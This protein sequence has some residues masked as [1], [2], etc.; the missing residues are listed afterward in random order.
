M[1]TNLL[2]SIVA[3]TGVM[4]GVAGLSRKLFAERKPDSA[5]GAATGAVS[6]ERGRH[7]IR[8]AGCNDC[9]TPGFMQEGENVPEGLWLTGVP[10]GW[11]GPWGTTYASNLRQHMAAWE[12]GREWIKMVRARNGLPP[13][14]WPSLHAMTDDELL[15]IHAYVRSLPVTGEAT[16]PPVPPDREPATPYFRMEPVMPAGTAQA[17][18]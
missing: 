5:P 1:N 18:Q 8:M 16:P 9:H 17:E 7:I 3:I 6:I 12:D 4:F 13:M 10:L 2:F 15:S 11:R 14:P